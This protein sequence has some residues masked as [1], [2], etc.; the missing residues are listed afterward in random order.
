LNALQ[1]GGKGLPFLPVRG[2]LG[3][4]YLDFN[5]NFKVIPDPFRGEDLAVVR[6]LT[7][8]VA[9]VH[10]SQADAYGN[11]LIPR[12]SDW[13]LAILAARQVVATVEE[14]VAGPLA[15]QPDWRLIPAIYLSALVYCPGGARPTDF[16][17][18]YGVD[19]E[20]LSLYLKHSRDAA[21]FVEYVREYVFGGG[22]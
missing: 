12:R 2:I 4:A 21:A 7:P 1:A 5:P 9:L 18:Y 13:H 11:L 6:A 16:P 20:H 15:D 3:S 14:R 19:E 17:P 22:G 8:D 10:G